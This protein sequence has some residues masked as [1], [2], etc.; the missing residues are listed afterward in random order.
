MVQFKTA[1]V[2]AFI[3]FASPAEAEPRSWTTVLNVTWSPSLAG[4]YEARVPNA[5]LLYERKPDKHFNLIVTWDDK[6]FCLLM[7][8]QG[9]ESFL[10][11]GTFEN[12]YTVAWNGSGSGKPVVDWTSYGEQPAPIGTK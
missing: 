5:T 2:L 4:G 10:A 3:A 12:Y 9:P 6:T 11:C 8:R 1:L 7:G